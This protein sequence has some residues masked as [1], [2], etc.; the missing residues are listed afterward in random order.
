MLKDQQVCVC[1]CV[2]QKEQQKRNDMRPFSVFPK[3]RQYTHT[4]VGYRSSLKRIIQ[5]RIP[6]MH[7][8]KNENAFSDGKVATSK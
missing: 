7:R 4:N 5:T 6:I 2:S 8:L 1:V 3:C